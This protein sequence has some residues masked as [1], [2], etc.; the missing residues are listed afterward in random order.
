MFC[1]IHYQAVGPLCVMGDIQKRKGVIIV[2][3]KPELTSAFFTK[4]TG[5]TTKPQDQ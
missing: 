5:H 4:I 2:C 3:I 1:N